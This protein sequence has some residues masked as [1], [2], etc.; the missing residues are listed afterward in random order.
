M[1]EL[2][3]AAYA[4]LFDRSPS[5]LLLPACRKLSLKKRHLLE[6]NPSEA[7]CTMEFPFEVGSILPWTAADCTPWP[8][9]RKGAGRGSD[10]HGVVLELDYGWI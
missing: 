3:L 7:F 9:G 10:G 4:S 2:H 5:I 6:S 8:W 1:L